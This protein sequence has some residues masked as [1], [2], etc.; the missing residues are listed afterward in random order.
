MLKSIS[1][2]VAVLLIAGAAGAE[3]STTY[4]VYRIDDRTG[5]VSQVGG[6][7]CPAGIRQIT[8]IK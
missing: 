7:Y 5:A 8:D 4:A 2:L 1:S 3:L 6:R